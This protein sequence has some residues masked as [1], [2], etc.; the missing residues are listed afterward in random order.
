MPVI[1][2]GGSHGSY[3]VKMFLQQFRTLP[4]IIYEGGD[5]NLCPPPVGFCVLMCLEPETKGGGRK[6][7]QHAIL[8]F[9]PPAIANTSTYYS[10]LPSIVVNVSSQRPQ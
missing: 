5:I 6:K 7:V 2:L 4:E 9:L 1:D 8:S 10:I 3:A